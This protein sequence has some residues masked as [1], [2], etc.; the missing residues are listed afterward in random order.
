TG[1]TFD[2]LAVMLP[3]AAKIEEQETER[4]NRRADRA[5]EP[6]FELLY[7]LGDVERLLS[8][9]RTV[10]LEEQFEPVAGARARMWNA[11]HILGAA[12]VELAIDEVNLLFSGDL[13][14]EHKSFH[15]DP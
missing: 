13:G 1:P 11:G 9:V 4:R 14:P 15:L 8:L 2:L 10:E 6:P 3:D 7:T 5:G 12:S